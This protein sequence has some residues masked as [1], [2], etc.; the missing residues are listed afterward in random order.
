MAR[1]R[2]K[3]R[4]CIAEKSCTV[5]SCCAAGLLETAEPAYALVEPPFFAC[6]GVMRHDFAANFLCEIRK[7][8]VLI[9]AAFELGADPYTIWICCPRD[10]P[11]TGQVL[12]V[13]SHVVCHS[14]LPF[15]RTL[16]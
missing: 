11:L 8:G 9:S 10:L 13:Q 16:P 1:L 7:P 2:R 4:E 3:F 6:N 15:F 12:I 5:Q 14:A